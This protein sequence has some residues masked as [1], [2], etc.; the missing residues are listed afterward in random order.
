MRRSA[1]LAGGKGSCPLDLARGNPVNPISGCKIL[2]GD[3]ELDFALP[4]AL[5]LAWQRIYSSGQRLAGLLGQGWST[6]LSSALHISDGQL[7]I[8]DPF[9]RDITFALP[10]VGDAL[11]SLS[12]K[13]TLE[14]TGERN[15][16]LIDED[17]LRRQFAMLPRAYD[18]AVLVGMVDTN[19]NQIRI[20]WNARRLPES[21]QD[22]AGRVFVLDYIDHGGQVR[23]GSVKVQRDA[24][25]YEE[26]TSDLLVRYAYD[27]AGNLFQV[28]DRAGQVVRQFAYTNHIMVEHAQPGALVSR[29]EYDDYEWTGKVTRNWANN[30]MSWNFRYLNGETL[31]YDNLGRQE[32]F[33]FDKKRRF[34]GMVDPL[35][36]E[37]TYQLDNHGNVLAVVTPDG[38][39]TSYRYDRRSRLM[40]MERGGKG[41]GIVYD[42]KVD[43]PALFTDALG[44]T[45][46][47]RYDERGNLLSVTDALG[48]RTVYEYDARG[49]PVKVT[50]PAGGIKTLAYNRAAQPVSYT[51]CAGNTSSFSYDVD[52]RL[53]SATDTK[54]RA[55]TYTYDPAGRLSTMVHPDG[56]TEQVEYDTL[57]RLLARVDAAGR[58]T[59]YQLDVDG[60]P[61]KRTDSRGAVLEYRYDPLRRLAELIREN[62]EAHRFA[63]DPLDRLSEETGFDGRLTRYRYDNS[64]L[65]VAK[66]EHGATQG[67]EATR[68]DTSYTRDSAGRVVD[69]IMSRMNGEAGTEQ[70][71]L[72]FAYDDLGRMTQAT[73]DTA[74]VSLEYDAL[75]RLVTERTER[76]AETTLVRHVYDPLGEPIRTVLADGSV[77]GAPSAAWAQL[78]QSNASPAIATAIAPG[79]VRR[80]TRSGPMPLRAVAQAGA[81]EGA[82]P[83]I[84]Q[85]CDEA[86]SGTPL[87]AGD[88]QHGRTAWRD[89]VIGPILAALQPWPDAGLAFDPAHDGIDDGVDGDQGWDGRGPGF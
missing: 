33:R 72:R 69:K 2:A 89:E 48:Q 57:G 29:Y 38:R 20:T 1:A 64:G 39:S 22:S 12:E 80:H 19:D 56:S 6:P 43:K 67:K 13:I 23:L 9:Q 36:R 66:E 44:A 81:G 35:G 37:T 15:F 76:G 59:S 52:G 71:R 85:A 63:Y 87:P 68:I 10:R 30:G 79:K 62:G 73:D 88:P 27:D 55:T 78:H 28:I 58:R 54:G 14:R 40:R 41:T 4:A 70:L 24:V 45:T 50:D 51:D 46:A 16:E 17:G 11:Y 83:L 53:L 34:T 7:I 5:P 60:K 82:A 84:A 65:L 8:L 18:T 77:P 26:P 3:S 32:L 86:G 47:L 25:D 42:T 49:L 21:V 31:V 75:G 74:I 61:I